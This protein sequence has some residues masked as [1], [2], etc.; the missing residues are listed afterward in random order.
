MEPKTREGMEKLSIDTIRKLSL[1]A[2]QS[3]NSGDA[4]GAGA[5]VGR[6]GSNGGS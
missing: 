6:P 3:A 2:V 4:E 1:D 5:L